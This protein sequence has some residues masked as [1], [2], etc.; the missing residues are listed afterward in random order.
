M[1]APGHVP[2]VPSPKS[3]TG[4]DIRV[5]ISLFSAVLSLFVWVILF[6]FAINVVS[7]RGAI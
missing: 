7:K 3:G 2:S 4:M 1:E 5:R 6:C